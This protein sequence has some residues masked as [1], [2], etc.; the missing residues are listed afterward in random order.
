MNHDRT[1]DEFV[2]LKNT[3]GYDP[4][5]VDLLPS[6]INSALILIFLPLTFDLNVDGSVVT[7]PTLPVLQYI[8]VASTVLLVH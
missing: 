3:V 4:T 2:C 7:I 5:I 6:T 1:K 8:L